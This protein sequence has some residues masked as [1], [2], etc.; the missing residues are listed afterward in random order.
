MKIKLGWFEFCADDA[1][2]VIMTLIVSV[3]TVYA[4]VVLS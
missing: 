1:A 3:F 4:L 2:V